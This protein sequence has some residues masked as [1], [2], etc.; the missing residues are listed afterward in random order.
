MYHRMSTITINLPPLRER[1]DD[2]PHLI[3]E[4]LLQSNRQRGCAVPSISPEA[5]N[6]CLTYG[7]PGNIQE[8]KEAIDKAVII[9]R[10]R[11]IQRE[12]LPVQ[13]QGT[14][15]QHQWPIVL[16]E[17]MN[18]YTVEKVLIERALSQCQTKKEAAAMLGISLKTLYNKLNRYRLYERSITDS[19]VGSIVRGEKAEKE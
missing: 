13:V 12:H 8:L 4:F 11:P 3:G 14:E 17:N 1:R 19:G 18:L 16:Y 7:W 10:N 6:L 15:Q 5:L 9:C 2:I